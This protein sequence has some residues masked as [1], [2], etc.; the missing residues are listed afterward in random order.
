MT[1]SIAWASP[2]S[3]AGD[4]F[5]TC[6]LSVGS[7]SKDSGG[8][9]LYSL[10]VWPGVEEDKHT[11]ERYE[12]GMCVGGGREGGNGC[13]VLMYAAMSLTRPRGFVS[14]HM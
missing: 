11:L 8:G 5:T 4:F 10:L 2:D 3:E 1:C 6:V 12:L 9:I 7:I 13:N 14:V